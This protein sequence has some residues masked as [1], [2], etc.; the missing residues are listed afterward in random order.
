MPYILANFF[1]S[2][3][4]P[5]MSTNQKIFKNLV[6]GC[7]LTKIQYLGTKVGFSDLHF[8]NVIVMLQE[9]SLI[10]QKLGVYA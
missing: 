9:K 5:G 10:F 4:L 1:K 3:F 6:R 2:T 7:M 8:V